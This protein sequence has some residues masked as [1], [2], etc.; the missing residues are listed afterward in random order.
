MSTHP[1]E[2][3]LPNIVHIQVHK[4]RVNLSDF[5]IILK[6]RYDRIEMVA[7]EYGCK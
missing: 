3:T 7:S 2:T 1:G 4:A 6:D 5:S